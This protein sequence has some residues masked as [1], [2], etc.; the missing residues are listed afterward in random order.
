MSQHHVVTSLVE[1]NHR[2]GIEC[3]SLQVDKI[4]DLKDV[5]DSCFDDL[6]YLK[7][8]YKYN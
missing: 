2:G 4:P 6:F 1:L 7:H 8:S 5:F 3:F